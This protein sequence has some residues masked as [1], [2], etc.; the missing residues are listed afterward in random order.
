MP[1]VMPPVPRSGS[2]PA[3]LRRGS[4]EHN[5]PMHPTPRQRLSHVYYRGA[6]VIAG[7]R[8]LTYVDSLSQEMWSEQ[9]G[10]HGSELYF[11]CIVRRH[12]R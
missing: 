12:H 5:K 11:E 8:P 2:S 9:E 7:V 10:Q 6:R 4:G 1:G 3:V